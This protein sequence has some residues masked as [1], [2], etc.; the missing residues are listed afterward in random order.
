[1]PIERA[2]RQAAQAACALYRPQKPFMT[3]LWCIE[4]VRL[5]PWKSKKGIWYVVYEPEVARRVPRIKDELRAYVDSLNVRSVEWFVESDYLGKYERARNLYYPESLKQ[6]AE[7]APW[8]LQGGRVSDPYRQSLVEWW[9]R[10][11]PSDYRV[12]EPQDIKC[13]NTDASS[14]VCYTREDGGSDWTYSAES[15]PVW[16]AI[17]KGTE[18]WLEL[19]SAAVPNQWLDK[20]IEDLIRAN[21][22]ALESLALEVPVIRKESG[23]GKVRWARMSSKNVYILGRMFA[24][25]VQDGENWNASLS[26][27]GKAVNTVQAA[28][29]CWKGGFDDWYVGTHG[30]DWLAWCPVCNRFHSGD[31]SN[32]DLHETARQ[33]LANKQAFFHTIEPFLDPEQKRWYYA[34]SYL[35]IRC[36]TLWMWTRKGHEVVSVHRTLGKVRSGSGEFVLDNN[37]N[38][39]AVLRDLLPRAHAMLSSRRFPCRSR[40]WWPLFSRL[41]E[42]RYGWVAKPDAQLTNPHGFVVC[43]CVHTA[44]RGFFPSP[45]ISSVIR[46]WVNPSYDPEMFPNNSPEIMTARFRDYDATLGWAPKEVAERFRYLLVD[47]AMKAGVRD[48]WGL[49]MSEADLSRAT[50]LICEGYSTRSYLEG[51]RSE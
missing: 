19:I 9:G 13:P 4:K 7:V 2:L 34:L 40:R 43:R 48:P 27:I 36:P 51:T 33:Q 47:V 30:D 45:C 32:F 1:L 41:A 23:P 35:A 5:A 31:W 15:G 17:Q 8:F 38:N 22:P 10:Y 3:N 6:Q 29:K 11:T 28:I 14:G 16:E 39:Y 44:D 46:N 24:E 49:E 25:R 12:L 18:D 50:R 37:A 42:E 26:Y 20:P 21:C